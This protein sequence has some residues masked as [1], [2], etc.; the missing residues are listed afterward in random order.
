[1][2]ELQR[3]PIGNPE[4]A[5]PFEWAQARMPDGWHVEGQHLYDAYFASRHR[6]KGK[7]FMFGRTPAELVDNV[8]NGRQDFESWDDV[9]LAALRAG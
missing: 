4:S 3:G 2:T 6:G 7:S 8:I 9:R 5:D 1:M